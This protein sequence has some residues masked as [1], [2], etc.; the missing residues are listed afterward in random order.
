MRKSNGERAL[1]LVERLGISI[2]YNKSITNKD[3]TM[4]ARRCP[5]LR[6][7]KLYDDIGKL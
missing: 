1:H 4:I 2:S 3:I 5:N 6:L 7:L